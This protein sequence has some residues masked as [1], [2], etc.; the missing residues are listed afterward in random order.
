MGSDKKIQVET[1]FALPDKQAIVE[2]EVTEGTTAIEAVRQ[3][4]IAARFE[5]LDVEEA[6]LGIFGKA[7][8]NAQVLKA[9]DRVEIYRPL[10][11]DPKEIRKARAEKAKE[12][13]A[14]ASD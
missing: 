3:S 5:G 12:R 4:N 11:A 13:R 14:A 10:V 9:G 7:V 6:R 1:A 2:L 8:T